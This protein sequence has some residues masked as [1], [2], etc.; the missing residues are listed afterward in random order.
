MCCLREIIAALVRG[1]VNGKMAE[2][3][4]GVTQEMLF[5]KVNQMLRVQNW[6]DITLKGVISRL[7]ADFQPDEEV[8]GDCMTPA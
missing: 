4:D 5:E 3:P 1:D 2:L 6:D 8:W 7:E